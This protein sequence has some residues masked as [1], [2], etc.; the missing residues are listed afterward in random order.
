MT[1]TNT[2]FKDLLA[3]VEAGDWV[4]PAPT[5][6]RGIETAPTDGT[7]IIALHA[8]NSG[9]FF[10]RYGS[11]IG[12]SSMEGWFDEEYFDTVM[13]FNYWLSVPDLPDVNKTTN[14]GVKNA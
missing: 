8:D 1:E 3:K 5:G 4:D 14:Q 6:W 9:V 12:N 11:F 2:V 7:M 10:A 13:N